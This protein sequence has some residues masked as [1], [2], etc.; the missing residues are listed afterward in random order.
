MLKL[1]ADMRHFLY[2]HD[3][4]N[5]VLPVVFTSSFLRSRANPETTKPFLSEENG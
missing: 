4:F 2:K 1:L 3:Y 5:C